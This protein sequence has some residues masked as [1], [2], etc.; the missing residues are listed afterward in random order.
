MKLDNPLCCSVGSKDNNIEGKSKLL[1]H[2]VGSSEWEACVKPRMVNSLSGC[3][4]FAAHSAEERSD[5]SHF[6]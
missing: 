4:S 3:L 5:N 1:L 6:Q 2:T